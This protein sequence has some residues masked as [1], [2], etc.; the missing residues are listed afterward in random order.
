MNSASTLKHQYINPT[1][2]SREEYELM[3]CL[4]AVSGDENA[5]RLWRESYGKEGG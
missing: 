3:L 4:Q 5:R 2:R 1:A